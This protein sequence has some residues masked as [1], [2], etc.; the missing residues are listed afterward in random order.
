MHLLICYTWS[1]SLVVANEY[2][3]Q[4]LAS[5][6]PPVQWFPLGLHPALTLCALMAQ[7]SQLVWVIIC[8][9]SL[10]VIV[11]KSTVYPPAHVGTYSRE[12]K[13]ILTRLNLRTQ[14]GLTEK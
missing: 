2:S 6:G 14:V 8:E 7:L 3:S 12:K 10:G 13:N 4:L 5:G 11:A 1:A 9:G